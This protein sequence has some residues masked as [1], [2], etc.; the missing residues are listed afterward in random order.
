MKE[1][2]KTV[3]VAENG[4]I[5]EDKDACLRYENFLKS[6]AVVKVRYNT[7]LTEGRYELKDYAYLLIIGIPIKKVNP[8]YKDKVNNIV[9]YWC[10]QCLGDRI[11]FPQGVFSFD[12]AM[13]CWDYSIE[14]IN[15]QQIFT[16]ERKGNILDIITPYEFAGKFKGCE[17]ISDESAI[18]FIDTFL[19]KEGII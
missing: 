12:G 16:E 8:Y 5:F 17:P 15:M 4:K 1:V 3:F 19:E 13:R 7:D 2:Q 14:D 18:N 6:V 11:G 10:E 9:T